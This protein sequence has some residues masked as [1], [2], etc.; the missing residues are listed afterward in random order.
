MR[1]R[2]IVGRK[3]KESLNEQ[4]N[5]MSAKMFAYLA[6]SAVIRPAQTAVVEER[7]TWV[8][9]PHLRVKGVFCTK[10]QGARPGARGGGRV[11]LARTIRDF[12][13]RVQSGKQ[14]CPDPFGY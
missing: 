2:N 9:P 4:F 5:H 8:A 10:P 7:M 12:I 3:S 11:A 13:L 6:L 1:R 14:I